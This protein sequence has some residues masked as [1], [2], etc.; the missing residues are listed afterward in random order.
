M[1]PRPQSCL[2]CVL[3][4]GTPDPPV[5]LDSSQAP[6]PHLLRELLCPAV[7]CF[8]PRPPQGL[9]VNTQRA[10]ADAQ[11][12]TLAYIAGR[13]AFVDCRPGFADALYALGVEPPQRIAACVLSA[14]PSL[15]SS[16]VAQVDPAAEGA[17]VA[18]V[19][20]ACVQGWRRAVLDGGP[21]RAFSVEDHPVL[22]EDLELLSQF[23][24]V[25][26]V[27]IGEEVVRNILKRPRALL[28]AFE[29]D[30]QTLIGAERRRH[31]QFSAQCGGTPQ[32]LISHS[33][34]SLPP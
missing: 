4:E 31:R 34:K 23:F 32:C 2:R 6:C 11:Q 29:L 21:G 28:H 24:S 1:T 30:T 16:A 10:L 3:Q 27:G 22:E 12:H 5:M 14:L 7:Y 33:F 25:Q 15:L 18:A 8:R 13:V 19:L 17:C 20:E 26:R 9:M